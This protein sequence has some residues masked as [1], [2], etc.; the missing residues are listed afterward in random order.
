MYRFPVVVPTQF[1]LRAIYPT[2]QKYVDRI[3]CG[4]PNHIEK[5][6][7]F[8]SAVTLRCGEDS[9]L[10]ILLITKRE[11]SDVL[12]EL[13]PIY[14]GIGIDIDFVIKTPDEILNSNIEKESTLIQEIKEKGVVVYERIILTC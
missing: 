13:S 12:S 7:V 2:M 5:V 8:G 11:Q 6:I 1:D 3:L 9:D 4:L 10:D 14:R